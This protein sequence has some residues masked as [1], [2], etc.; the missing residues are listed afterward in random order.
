[1]IGVFY[2][3]FALIILLEFR[4][5]TV[6]VFGFDWQLKSYELTKK[7]EGLKY[8]NYSTSNYTE[9]PSVSFL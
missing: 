2:G 4:K 6:R 5:V 1:M 9:F 7:Q 3:C 8:K